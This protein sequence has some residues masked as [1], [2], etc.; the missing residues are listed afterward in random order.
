MGLCWSTIFDLQLFEDLEGIM[1]DKVVR[2]YWC[3]VHCKCV[4]LIF[5]LVDDKERN[6]ME[7]GKNIP[8]DDVKLLLF[9]R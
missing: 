5:L 3:A 7:P 9:R 8:A 1:R 4:I 6:Y 2:Q